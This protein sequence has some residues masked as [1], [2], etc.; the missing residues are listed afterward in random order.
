MGGK[1]FTVNMISEQLCEGIDCRGCERGLVWRSRSEVMGAWAKAGA[2][3]TKRQRQAES[4]S[5]CGTNRA[6]GGR[7]VGE[8]RLNSVAVWPCQQGL[9]TLSLSVQIWMALG[10]SL[11]VFS[12]FKHVTSFN[13]M[14]I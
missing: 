2:G 1:N 11:A 3:R 14:E 13:W 5:G 10:I 6:C 4:S 8:S 7:G 9:L 12:F